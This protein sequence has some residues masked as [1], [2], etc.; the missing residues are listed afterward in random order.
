[1]NLDLHVQV[2]PLDEGLG[3]GHEAKPHPGTENLRKGVEPQNSALRVHGE[4]AGVN[5]TNIL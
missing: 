1:M 3:P 2:D 4:E 5:F